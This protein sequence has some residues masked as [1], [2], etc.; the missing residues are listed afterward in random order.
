MV[1]N[2]SYIPNEGDYVEGIEH[3][4]ILGNKH[5]ILM[6]G[7]VDKVSSNSVYIQA[8]DTYNGDRGTI[9][10]LDT[11][12]RVFVRAPEWW[13]TKDRRVKPNTVVR[14]FKNN[15][16][17]VIGYAT[18]VSDGPSH[19]VVMYFRLDN[20][21]QIY[22]RDAIEFNSVVDREKYPNVNQLY[23]FEEVEND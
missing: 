12:R 16:Y 5:D 23:I 20:P 18:D 4:E 11:V 1:H 14:H 22:I 6:R 13:K 2:N 7:W 19:D 8:D 15:L 9:L 21:E 3:L 10:D 17:K